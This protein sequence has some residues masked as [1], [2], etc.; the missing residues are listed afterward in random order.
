MGTWKSVYEVL[1]KDENGMILQ[2]NVISIQ[3][4]DSIVYSQ[5]KLTAVIGVKNIAVINTDDATLIMPIEEAEKVKE[6]VNQL[7][8]SGLI[9]YL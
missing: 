3:S 2:G 4:Q 5:D 9:D 7:N 1:S 8:D 6:I